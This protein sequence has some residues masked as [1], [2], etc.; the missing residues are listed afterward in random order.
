MARVQDFLTLPEYRIGEFDGPL[1]NMAEKVAVD[2]GST[3]ALVRTDHPE[4]FKL[5]NWTFCRGQGHT[6]TNTR[7][8]LSHF[9]T[10][11]SKQRRSTSSLEI[12][13][14]RPFE[15]DSV[16]DVYGQLSTGMWG[17]QQRS[18]ETWQWL[19]GRKAHAQI[20]IAVKR[21]SRKHMMPPQDTQDYEKYLDPH[22]NQI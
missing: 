11:R 16:K 6:R 10:T 7:A 9:D 4:R 5:N 8:I 13:T 14:W 3:L 20:L 12:R 1:L 19:A 22:E 2:E 18:D 21:E 17:A 15:I